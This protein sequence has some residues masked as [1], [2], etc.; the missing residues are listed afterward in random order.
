MEGVKAPVGNICDP[1]MPLSSF[2]LFE[3][4]MEWCIIKFKPSMEVVGSGRTLCLVI[5]Q[6][7]N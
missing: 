3:P 1:Q 5:F 6:T 7:K 2:V 4:V